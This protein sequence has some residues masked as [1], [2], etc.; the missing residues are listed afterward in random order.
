MRDLPASHYLNIYRQRLGM[1][2]KGITHPP[3]ETVKFVRE[4]VGGLSVLPPDTK[5]RLYS[6][7]RYCRFTISDSGTLL[8]E[9]TF[10]DTKDD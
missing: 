9:I 2:E 6:E 4:L 8:A 7:G 10:P 5:I 3:P 1:A